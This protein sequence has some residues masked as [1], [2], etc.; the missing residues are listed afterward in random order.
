[1]Q[2]RFIQANGLRFHI[3]EAGNQTDPLVVLLHGFPE[4]HY[5]WR[6]QIDVLAAAGYYVVAP[7]QRGYNLSDKPASIMDYDLD[8][9]AKDVVEIILALGHDTAIVI[10]HDWG[11]AVAWWTAMFHP[12]SVR[13]LGILN[14][15]HLAVMMQTLKRNPLQMLK[16]W[17]IVFFQ[18]P[19]LPEWSVRIF[20][21]WFSKQALIRS[22]AAGTFTPAELQ[23]YRDAWAQPNAFRSMLNW[24]RATSRSLVRDRDV[25]VQ[26][27]T[28]IIWGEQDLFLHPQMARD[29]LAYCDKARLE[30][31]P[32][33]SHWVQHEAADDVNRLLLEFLAT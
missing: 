20:D 31:L 6:K 21:Y 4:F 13:K 22:S 9:L 17:Y 15:P 32:E 8:H 1:M 12:A 11:A 7:D 26:A 27:P 25:H 10:G 30:M 24:Y 5:G 16:S 23:R 14:V 2:T 33:A 18:L 29:S 28:L 19:W 3:A